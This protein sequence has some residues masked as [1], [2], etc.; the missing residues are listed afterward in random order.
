MAHKRY[1]ALDILYKNRVLTMRSDIL[2]L[3]SL[4]TVFARGL[5]STLNSTTGKSKRTAYIHSIF[6]R[7]QPPEVKEIGTHI[8]DMLEHVASNEWDETASRIIAVLADNDITLYALLSH[9][10]RDT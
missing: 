9:D 4:L 7:T 10:L 2:A 3:D 5:P 8:A 6:V 1:G